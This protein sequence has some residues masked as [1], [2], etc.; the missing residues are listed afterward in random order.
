[1]KYH[2]LFLHGFRGTGKSTVGRIVAE[3]LGWE[4]IE[5]DA[6]LVERAGKSIPEITQDGTDWQTFRQMEQD[7]L[8]E[9][10]TRT[11][12]VVST[13]GGACVNNIIKNGS[14]EQFGELNAQ[15][16]QEAEKQG[17]LSI[18]VKATDEEIRQRVLDQEMTKAETTRPIL[19]EQRAA[20]IQ[21]ELQQHE[22]DEQRQKEILVQAILD[23]SMQMY[24][25]RKPLYATITSHIVDTTTKTPEETVEDIIQLIHS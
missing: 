15:I 4:Y 12:I 24:E 3:R 8:R 21:N 20:E 9:L 25:Q 19:N 6:L 10:S 1:M 16:M 22:G 11:N 7:L 18:L 2:A 14:G 23:D 5:M 17:A 13:G